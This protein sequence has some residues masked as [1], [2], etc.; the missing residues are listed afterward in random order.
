MNRS[1]VAEGQPPGGGVQSVGADDE[2]EAADGRRCSKV[3]VDAVTRPRCHSSRAAIESPKR[4]STSVAGAVVEDAGEVAAHDLV[5]AP[6]RGR[7]R[8]RRGRSAM[9][10]AGVVDV[11]AAAHVRGLGA[12]LVED[13]HPPADLDRGAADVDLVAAGAQF[14]GALDDGRGEAVAVQPEGEG[15]AGD[16]GAGDEDRL[17]RACAVVRRCCFVGRTPC[18]VVGGPFPCPHDLTIRMSYTLV[19]DGC[20]DSW[21]LG[22][23]QSG[24][25]PPSPRSR[26]SRPCPRPPPARGRPPSALAH[27]AA[28]RLAAQLPYRLDQQE[29]PAHP[30]MAGGE[31]AAVGVDRQLAVPPQPALLD[32]RAA[33][34]LRAEAQVLQGHQRHV[35]EG[36]VDLGDIDVGRGARPPARRR[37]GPRPPPG[38]R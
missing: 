7:R 8:C 27:L 30:G 28:A 23:G 9:V 37:A 1:S 33:L 4:Y 12:D 17:A 35:G 3:T 18:R 15:G 24:P 25:A 20:I 21:R 32:E 6:R 5:V 29:Q 10:A 31:A 16:R 26:T 14:G 19:Y 11:R 13:A 2:V 34:A 22:R 36:V 38:R